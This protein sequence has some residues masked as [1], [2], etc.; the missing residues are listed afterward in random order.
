M[1]LL[2]KQE[3]IE[4]NEI[5]LAKNAKYFRN[6]LV[7]YSV[8]EAP[9]KQYL[10]MILRDAISTHTLE[11]A[12]DISLKSTKRKYGSIGGYEIGKYRYG[13]HH[14]IEHK[15]KETDKKKAN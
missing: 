12:S 15:E 9:K 11:K 10:E 2:L 1:V 8:D 7:L 14:V 4:L 3:S 13:Y 6:A 5:F